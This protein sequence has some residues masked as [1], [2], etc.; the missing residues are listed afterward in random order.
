MQ[1]KYPISFPREAI[2]RFVFGRG[3]APNPTGGAYSAPPHSSTGLRGTLLLRER[4]GRGHDTL[5]QIP[6]SAP[7]TCNKLCASSHDCGQQARPSTSFVDNTIDLHW[8]NFLSP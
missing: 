5:M 6:G 1:K 3:S 7:G 8:Q 4:G 2:S